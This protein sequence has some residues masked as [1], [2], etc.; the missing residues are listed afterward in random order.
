ML[1]RKGLHMSADPPVEPFA[2]SLLKEYQSGK[3]VE[4]LSREMGIPAERIEMRLKAAAAY[5]REHPQIDAG[6]SDR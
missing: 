3:T 5:L 6:S 1:K 2:L 4:A